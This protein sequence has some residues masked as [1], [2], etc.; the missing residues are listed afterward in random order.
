MEVMIALTIMAMS[1]VWVLKGQ[2]DSIVRNIEARM[3]LQ[4]MHLAQFKVL[5]IEQLLRK[6]GFGTF[7]GE[8]CGDFKDD[9]LEGTEIF[10]YCIYIEKIEFPDMSQLQQQLA[11]GL[12]M[13]DGLDESSTEST[14]PPFMQD[15]L[16][17]LFTGGDGMDLMSG[18]GGMTG[19]ILTMA[20]SGI[21]NVMEQAV[22]KVR[23]VVSWQVGK[24]NRNFEL[25]TF[26]TD[27]GILDQNI[28]DL[29]GP[30]GGGTG[31]TPNTGPS[32]NTR[33]S[34]PS[35]GQVVR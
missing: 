14:L 35:G 17:S 28:T 31:S 25:V 18:L 26:F 3:R 24:K 33:P 21:Q 6:E 32:G 30:S 1:L 22:R 34:T 4:G 5:E 10:D 20:L 19:N 16:G 29:L 13:S 8:L 15:M 7:E 2:T 9:K 12:G 23:V 11:G 27:P